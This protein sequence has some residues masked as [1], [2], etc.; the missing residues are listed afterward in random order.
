VSPRTLQTYRLSTNWQAWPHWY[1]FTACTEFI[2]TQGQ[3]FSACLRAGRPAFYSRRRQEFFSL[4]RPGRVWDPSNHLPKDTRGSFA[5]CKAAGP[6]SHHSPAWSAEV[7]NA[8]SYT[9]TFPQVFMLWC[10][11][12]HRDNFTFFIVKSPSWETDS[13]SV[14]QDVPR[15]LWN[16]SIISVFTRA[17][18]FSL[19]WN[20]LIQS[21]PSLPYL[22]Y[23][24]ILYCHL[25]LNLPS[26]F[27]RSGLWTRILYGFL[28]SLCVLHGPSIPSSLVLFP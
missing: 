11:I 19:C 15:L 21:M 4:P 2:L 24:L 28:I 27:F 17:H 10:L 20:N 6:W 1:A 12:K 23:I 25:R 7:K 16:P 14:G 8:L 26:G 13:H 9:S 18:H 5:G 3:F 22:R